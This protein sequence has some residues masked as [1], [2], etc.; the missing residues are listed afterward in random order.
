MWIAIAII[1]AWF[2]IAA[3]V[4]YRAIR[5]EHT[6]REQWSENLREWI[7]DRCDHAS[8]RALPP[9]HPGE[10][11]L[12]LLP[13][14]ERSNAEIAHSLGI[15]LQMLDDLLAARHTVTSDLASQLGIL[16]G[17]GP[18]LWLN[19]QKRWDRQHVSERVP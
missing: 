16:C 10:L 13:A 6:N 5:Q 17:N 9:M 7:R 1:A 15:S 19:L 12:D 14:L 8:N 18:D 11:L 2:L 3:I 4:F